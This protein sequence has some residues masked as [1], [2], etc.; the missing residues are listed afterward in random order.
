MK[1]L[2]GSRSF[3]ALQM[4]N[5]VPFGP[6]SGNSVALP[7]PF[8]HAIFA[9]VTN[10]CLIS[11]SDCFCRMRFSDGNQRNFIRSPSDALGCRGN[12]RLHPLHIFAQMI[13][14]HRVSITHADANTR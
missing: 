13:P 3:V 6:Q 7:F 9:K 11:S 14:V 4:T 10:S 12:P 8:L 2:G 1:R 5:Q